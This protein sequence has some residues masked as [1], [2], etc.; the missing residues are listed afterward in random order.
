[1]NLSDWAWGLIGLILTVM[2]LSY[3]IGDNFLFRL[4][5]HI[6]I[7]LTAGY[8]L[9]LIVHQIIW[10]YFVMPI[11]NGSWIQRAW[12][13]VPLLLMLLLVISQI[14]RFSYLGAVPLSFLLGATAAIVIGGAVFGTLLPQIITIVGRFDPATWYAVPEQTWFKIVDA[15]V[16][17]VGVVAVLSFFHFGRRKK[18]YSD[19]DKTQR[20]RIIE[21]MSKIGQVFIGI[22]LGAIFAGVFSSALWALI[23]R[24]TFA[25]TFFMGLFGGL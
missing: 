25:R 1:M 5:A 18:Q 6:F 16:M 8:V 14:P 9:V 11:S 12:M 19:D 20:P 17:L 24:I 3:I 23:D 10:P 2:I 4:A 22:T 7:G 21:S 13:L 15:V